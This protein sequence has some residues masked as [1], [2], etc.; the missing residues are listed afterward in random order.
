V[1]IVGTEGYEGRH[2]GIWG[3]DGMKVCDDGRTTI[4][5]KATSW[6]CRTGRIDGVLHQWLMSI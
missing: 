1:G 6:P 5:L 4:E 3:W 2:I